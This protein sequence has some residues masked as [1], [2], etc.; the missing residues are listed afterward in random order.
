MAKMDKK[1]VAIL[2]KYGLITAEERD[3][4]VDEAK[5]G[6]FSKTLVESGRISESALLGAL[7][8]EL[9]KPA[10]D[11]DKITVP[12]EVR[13]RISQET[14][15]KYM[16]YPVSEIG[17]ILTLAVANP[18]DVFMLDDIRM[19]TGCELMPVISTDLAIERALAKKQDEQQDA[20]MNELLKDFGEEMSIVEEQIDEGED[21]DINALNDEDSPIV[22]MCNLMIFNALKLGASDIHIEPMEKRTRLRYRVD[23][24]CQEAVAPPK[25]L[26]NAVI[27]RFKILSDMDIAERKKPLDGKM[28][29]KIGGRRVD[30]RVN[31]L[32]LVHGEKMVLRILD[33][34]GLALSLDD[35]GFEP[36]SLKHFKWAISA[37][38]GMILV[39]GPT[40]SGKS[41][42][43]Y[44][45]L[46]ETMNIED[47]VSTVENPV[48]YQLEGINQCQTNDKRGMTFAAALRALLRQDPDTIM[49]GEIR[50]A[51]TIG[52][53]IKAALT[54]HLLLSTLHTNDAPGTIT[55]MIDMGVD[56]FNVTTATLMVSA[57]RLM[58]KICPACKQ[59][60]NP[61]RER[62]LEIG[63]KEEELETG[64][65]FRTPDPKENKCEVC[66]GRGMKGRFAVLE[67]MPMSEKIQRIVID[68]GSG[69]DI[70]AQA[71][72]EGMI[73]L[74]RCAL[75]NAMRGKTTIENVLEMTQDEA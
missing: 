38:Y 21:L 44:S 62:L 45:A 61:P 4:A 34:S 20:K 72:E 1:I 14:C 63:I 46:K 33:S 54:G 9:A 15:V 31:T 10:I 27:S 58:R 42:T 51:E 50:D 59:Q 67:T 75:L 65:W 68:G 17:G 48:E 53:A 47:N 8:I 18:F 40:G 2:E 43:L 71:L 69:M 35:L 66:G 24:A 37:P 26:H 29:M 55:R 52:I 6:S 22:K 70:R 5:N 28:Q 7:S 25:S 36:S 73:T 30:F 32:P 23:G 60:W 16:V 41:T 57:Q 39:T 74:R 11:L 64:I 19:V 12:D 49:V 13:N 3:K 56:R